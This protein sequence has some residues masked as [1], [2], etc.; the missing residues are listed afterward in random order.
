MSSP[1]VSSSTTETIEILAA[2]DAAVADESGHGGFPEGAWRALRTDGSRCTIAL[3]P[4][5]SVAAVT[6][7]SDSFELPHRQL[8]VAARD[9]A[10]APVLE[11]TIL[12][13]LDATADPT[14][15]WLPGSDD[16]IVGALEA[17]GFGIARRQF[18]MR[19][20]LPVDPPVI[21]DGIAVRSFALGRDEE[22]WLRVNNRAFL[23][24]PD[25]GGWIRAQLDRRMA[26]PWFDAAGFLLAVADETLV[27]FCWTK[28]HPGPEPVGEIFVIGVDPD[29]HGRG[30][31]RM[32]VAAGLDH[33]VRAR[34][35]STALLYVA[36]SNAPA[37][38][39]YRSFGFVVARTD[40][41][42]ERP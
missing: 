22:A 40:T 37:V 11:A 31:G 20:A 3:A 6:F 28:V 23:N 24:H 5:A 35:C 8:A 29:A 33:L 36:E 38:A 41:A 30:L 42:L 10:T 32:L 16:R 21:P 4:D 13:A 14:T 15:A 34:D 7:P 26:E 19:V 9:A 27:G 39:L 25:Q 1:A 2:L 12:G 17:L 18:Q